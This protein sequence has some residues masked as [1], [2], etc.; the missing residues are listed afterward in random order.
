MKKMYIY[1]NTSNF[2]VYMANGSIAPSN[3]LVTQNFFSTLSTYFENHVFVSKSLLSREIIYKYSKVNNLNPLILE[4]LIDLNEDMDVLYLTK[5]LKLIEDKFSNYSKDEYIGFLTQL[6]IPTDNIIKV[7]DLEKSFIPGLY[8]DI[9]INMAIINKSDEL[10]FSND[11]KLE[12]EAAKDSSN[13]NLL[14]LNKEL[15]RNNIFYDRVKGALVSV[16]INSFIVDEKYKILHNFDETLACLF[17]QKLNTIELARKIY[18]DVNYETNYKFNPSNSFENLLFKNLPNIIKKLSN[19]SKEH[20]IKIPNSVTRENWN[21]TISL[22]NTCIKINNVSTNENLS[23]FTETLKKEFY[24]INNST[25]FDQTKFTKLVDNIES[26][27]SKNYD[28]VVPLIEKENSLYPIKFAYIIYNNLGK[29][30]DDLKKYFQFHDYKEKDTRLIIFIFSLLI[31]FS[32]LNK[33]IKRKELI[34][35]ASEEILQKNINFNHFK[36]VEV[37]EF[38]KY[39]GLTSNLKIISGYPLYIVDYQYLKDKLDEYAYKQIIKSFK[40]NSINPKY[41]S[42]QIFKLKVSEPVDYFEIY[43]FFCGMKGK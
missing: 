12:F 17:K 20:K 18:N 21:F 9:F 38:M 32:G 30:V 24:L 2:E 15:V 13:N 19:T 5:E 22:I 1:T 7:Y 6:R 16:L 28:D 10:V 41:I 14:T 23:N 39:R 11:L 43:S 40:E 26:I 4:T 37:S 25:L 42:K 34:T 29:S 27:L 31:G 8:A 35:R 33:E 36:I 3:S